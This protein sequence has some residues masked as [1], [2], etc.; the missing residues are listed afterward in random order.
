MAFGHEPPATA[1][2]AVMCDSDNTRESAQALIQYIRIE[3]L[4]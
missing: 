3:G 1:S 2:L 4:R